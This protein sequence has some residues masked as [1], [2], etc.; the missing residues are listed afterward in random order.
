MKKIIKIAELIGPDI[1]SRQNAD[2]IR[3]SIGNFRVLLNSILMAWNLFPVL[4]Q[5][6]YIP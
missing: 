2:H 1:R 6:K 5:M 3:N 4:L